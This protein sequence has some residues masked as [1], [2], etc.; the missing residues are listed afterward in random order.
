MS[1]WNEINK[2]FK[3][4]S[5][6]MKVLKLMISYGLRVDSKGR[7]FCGDLEVPYTSVARASRTDRRTVKK[8]VEEI[9]KNP[10]LRE[11]FE[12]L[13]PAGPF[14]K[15]VAKI[16]GYRCLV[17]V[18]IQDR[19]GIIAAVTSIL[20]KRNINIVQ[21]IAEDPKLHEEPKLYI[22]VEGEIPG[23]AI[24]EI[25]SNPMIEKVTVQ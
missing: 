16:L 11:F 4:S 15:D 5:A 24:V 18:P 17:V 20:A 13:K 25:L 21:V 10:R 23:E 6:K 9:L 1:I 19:P 22:I 8:C 3:R 12:N 2:L 14:L 7:I